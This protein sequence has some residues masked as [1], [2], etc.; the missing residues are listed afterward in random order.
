[1]TIL[2]EQV[3]WEAV[4][5]K[6]ARMDGK[7]YYAVTSTGVYCR[8]SCPSR[9]PRRVN[10]RF[11][12][13]ADAAERA[14]YRACR[15][16]RP[17]V[18]LRAP[19]ERIRHYIDAHAG[20]KLTL[21]DLAARAGLS[22]AHLQRKFKAAFGV[23]PREYADARRA[24]RLRSELRGAA[25]VTDAIYG[26]GYG[27]S[28]RVYERTA[29]NLGM[30]PAAYR[31]GGR[32]VRIDYAT[33]HSPLGRVLVAA[34]GRGVCTIRFGDN[35]AEL[36]AGLRAEFP[37]AEVRHNQQAVGRW[38]EALLHHLREPENSLDLPLDLRA[39]AFQQKVWRHFKTIPAGQTES[40]Q[41]VAAAVGEPSAA[42]AVARACAANPVAVAIPCHRVVRADGQPGGYRW[43]EER[44]K[45]LLALER[46]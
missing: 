19:L 9:L 30:T 44:K 41:Q 38:M 4:Q 6:D 24:S 37:A 18:D 2:D 43:G 20:G 42:R 32:G 46:S 36:E 22:P 8:P 39:T 12:R 11:F 23:S 33:A 34:T 7:F 45:R 15:R 13:D 16:C 17:R 35:Q 27:S 31:E 5:T 10:V 3:W 26:A 29:E 1:M 21:A 25:S 40:Y 14:G 28:S